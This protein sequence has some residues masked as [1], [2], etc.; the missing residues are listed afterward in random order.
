MTQALI[1]NTEI[2]Q[3][4]EFIANVQTTMANPSAEASTEGTDKSLSQNFD[5]I[6]DKTIGAAVK[7]DDLKQND[8]EETALVL[9]EECLAIIDNISANNN[10]EINS[11]DE[12]LINQIDIE[13]ESPEIILFKPKNYEEIETEATK[14]NTDKCIDEEILNEL[15]IE[16]IEANDDFLNNET[17]TQ[18]ESP[19]E[20]GLK[21][22]LSNSVEKADV[23]F[24][25]TITSATNVKPQNVTPEKIIEQITKHIDSLKGN[26]GIKMV[27][28]PESL[29]KVN[30]QIINTKD[31]LSAQFTVTTNEARNLLMKGLDGLKETLITSGIGVDNLSIKLAETEESSYNP[32][33]TEQGDSQNQ[34]Q[35]FS[36][37]QREEKEKGLFEKTIAENMK[38]DNGKV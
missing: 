1:N 36:R 18:Q 30:L 5:E 35:N 28:N 23:T 17:M 33:W 15:N 10:K 9:I 12:S 22:M 29:G 3:N 34:G 26:S 4:N 14:N 19:E 7:T 38:N 13:E 16:S 21:V 6:L 2:F 31:G 24:D 32:D 20:L 27:L 11:I 25:K 8:N 37:Q